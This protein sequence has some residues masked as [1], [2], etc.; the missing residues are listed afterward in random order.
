MGVTKPVRLALRVKPGASRTAVGGRYD[1]PYGPALVVAVNAP[2]S[3][4]RATAAAVRAVA[5]ALQVKP[6]Q[7]AVRAGT[8][9][10]DKLL[11]VADPPEDFEDRVSQLREGPR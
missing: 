5:A 4:G 2:A 10:R 9:S 1:G 7:V 11:E 3:D 8:T 6:G